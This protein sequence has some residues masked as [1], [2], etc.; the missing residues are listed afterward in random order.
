MIT[1]DTRLLPNNQSPSERFGVETFLVCCK[2]WSRECTKVIYCQD[3]KDCLFRKKQGQSLLSVRK[4][5]CETNWSGKWTSTTAVA[6][7]LRCGASLSQE[8]FCSRP[9]KALMGVVVLL[10]EF[11]KDVFSTAALP[12]SN[13]AIHHGEKACSFAH[14]RRKSNWRIP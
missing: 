6:R 14:Q 8:V 9:P 3:F 10:K 5:K 4:S 2:N 12:P 1:D 13:F 11:L 7:N